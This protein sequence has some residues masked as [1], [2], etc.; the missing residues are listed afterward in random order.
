ME[1][2]VRSATTSSKTRGSARAELLA[3]AFDLVAGASLDEL[4][5]FV[6]VR[7]LTD[8]AGRSNG[9]LYSAFPG[10][11][12]AAASTAV[13][14]S[15]DEVGAPTVEL[16]ER[17]VDLLPKVRAGAE[18]SVADLASAAADNVEGWS[19]G[20]GADLFTTNLLAVAA[21]RNDPRAR[22]ALAA[23]YRELN[24]H[25][26]AVYD[27]LFDAWGREP[28]PEFDTPRLAVLLTCVADGL[29]MRRRFDPGVDHGF[30]GDVITAVWLACTRPVGSDD[31]T[32]DRLRLPDRPHVNPVKRQAI[33]D[34]VLSCYRRRGWEGVTIS[35][36]ADAAGVSRATVRA[37]VGDRSSLA[38][39]VWSQWVPRI[40]SIAA[41][42]ERP[43]LDQLGEVI[44][45]IA[46]VAADQRPVTAA[47]LDAMQAYSFRTGLPPDPTDVADPRNLV[48]L[49]SIVGRL[50]RSLSDQ[51]R[52]GFADNDR[53]A[54]ELGATVVN[55]TL[56]R[57]VT[58]TTDDPRMIAAQVVEVVL[59]GTLR[60]R[61]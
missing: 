39:V 43:R 42:R 53:A 56:L 36:V 58:R 51:F 35:S 25:Y 49:P 24:R 60:R 46:G 20:A 15:L 44:A 5:A 27:A 12:A 50:V 59:N 57:V 18:E 37:H 22:G 6:T 28:V 33:A 4:V 31:A 11:P 2:S 8:T 34:A 38:A 54:F 19:V 21:A 16:A 1:E 29:A 17:I 26:I 13:L 41:V 61:R 23:S 3:A 55:A 48:P 7:R 30:I 32:D 47:C 10:G 52:P 45:E 9:A 14:R 40:E